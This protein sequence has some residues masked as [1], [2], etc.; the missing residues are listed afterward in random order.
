MNSRGKGVGVV[1]L[2][3]VFV[4]AFIYG[5]QILVSPFAKP[6]ER[7]FFA[8]VMLVCLIGIVALSEA[9]RGK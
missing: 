9:F 5:L 2:I 6:E 3:A 8:T 7:I 4:G 1:A